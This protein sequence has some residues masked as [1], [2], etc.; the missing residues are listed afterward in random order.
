MLRK[1]AKSVLRAL[2]FQLTRLEGGCQTVGDM[3]AFLKHLPAM[4][5]TPQSLLDIGANAGW[6]TRLAK[7]AFPNAR[8]LLVEPQPEMRSALDSLCKELSDCT[9]AEVAVG[10]G[11]GT[12]VQTIWDDLQ[13]S[14]FLP[15]LDPQLL[16]TGRQRPVS[17]TT[18]DTLLHERDFPTPDLVKLD[19][20]GYEIEALRGAQR[21]MGTTE[22]FVM[23]CSL[24]AFMPGMPTLR[25]VICFMGERGYEPYD[26]PGFL[27]RPYDRALGQVDVAFAR[28]D[29]FLRRSS[30]WDTESQIGIDG[31]KT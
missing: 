11:Q 10:S 23:E 15:S 21:L 1:T 24:F 17:M 4:G 30:C 2:G 26:F 16:A 5:F 25:E 20:Q 22:L 31:H 18:I 29:G 8:A 13:G 6:W 12:S 3:G 19:I 14:S 7:S 27:R 28:R 9:W